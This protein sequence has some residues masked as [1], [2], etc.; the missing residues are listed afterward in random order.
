MNHKFC[1]K[2]RSGLFVLIAMPLGH[3]E[4]LLPNAKLL[5]I[6]LIEM[7]AKRSSAVHALQSDSDCLKLSE[8]GASKRGSNFESYQ[9]YLSNILWFQSIGRQNRTT[10][11]NQWACFAKRRSTDLFEMIPIRSKFFK[12]RFRKLNLVVRQLNHQAQ[13]LIDRCLAER[14]VVQMDSV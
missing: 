10:R 14:R 2:I 7:L 11:S 9:R 4:T 3:R 6:L 13:R 8:S 1:Q 12:F 5:I